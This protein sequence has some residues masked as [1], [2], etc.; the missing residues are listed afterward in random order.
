MPLKSFSYDIELADSLAFLSLEQIYV[1]GSNKTLDV[2]Y[3]FPVNPQAA[4]VDFEISFGGKVSK[5]IVMPKD[6]AEKQFKEHQEENR[7]VG[8]GGFNNSSSRDTMK[9]KIGN[10][11][12]GQEIKV[13]ISY[14]FAVTVL[15]NTFFEFRLPTTIT[16]RYVSQFD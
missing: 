16:P 1:N 10:I 11:S 6:E 5:G 15:V 7:G 4:V 9:V 8:M 12:S 3:V 2:Q 14:V 13:K